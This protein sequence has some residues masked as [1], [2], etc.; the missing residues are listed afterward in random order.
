MYTS[1]VT[2]YESVIIFMYVLQETVHVKSVLFYSQQSS[3]QNGLIL[4]EGVLKNTSLEIIL[5]RRLVHTLH[6]LSHRVTYYTVSSSSAKL[7]AKSKRAC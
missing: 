1:I 6:P 7:W 2:I 5:Y 4:A 3:I